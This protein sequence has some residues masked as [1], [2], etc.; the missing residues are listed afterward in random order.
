[1]PRRP[2][3]IAALLL[4]FCLVGGGIVYAQM[5]AGERGIMP[6]DSSGTLEID[7]IHVDVGGKDA[8]SARLGGWRIAQREGFR[9]LW[10]KSHGLPP[11]QAPSVSDSTLDDMVSS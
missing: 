2:L 1:M 4:A 10:A 11:S 6:L 9:M 7:G 8:Q 3:L 5:E